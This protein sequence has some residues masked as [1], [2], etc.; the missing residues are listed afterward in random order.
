[1]NINSVS[2][3]TIHVI[4]DSHA[5]AFKHKSIALP[6][7]GMIFS[8]NVSYVRG[9]QPDTI[10]PNGKL[11]NGIAQFLINEGLISGDGKPA[12][13]TSEPA[14]LS[15]QYATGECFQTELVVFNVGEIYVRKYLGTLSTDDLSDDAKIEADFRSVIE[16]YVSNISGMRRAFR[17]RFC[18]HE[19]TPPTA[20]DKAFEAVNNLSFPRER[21]GAVYRLFNSLLGQY[22]SKAGLDFCQSSDYLAD[23]TGCLNADYEFD[24]VH[25]DPKYSL[26][27]MARVVR[28]W[29][30]SR[31]SDSTLRY[32]TWNALVNVSKVPPKISQIGVSEPVQAVDSAQIERLRKAVSDLDYFICTRPKHDWGH[33]PPD[34]DFPK[35]KDVIKYGSISLDGLK[36][37]HDVFVVGSIG[38]S[39]RSQIGSKFAIIN[40]RPVESTPHDGDGIGQQSF[41][42]DNCPPGIFRGLLYL[43]DVEADEGGFEY[44]PV[45]GSEEPVQVLGKAGS[46]ILFDANAVDHRA[47]PPRTKTR[48][49]LDFIILAIPDDAD[50]IVH[51]AERG[52]IWPVDPYMFSLTGLCYPPSSKGKWFFPSLISPK[53]E[54]Q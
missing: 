8:A 43:V 45:D 5:L 19:L 3:K 15:E 36:L 30:Y 29:L 44:K 39:M 23:E 47:S 11:N 37:L 20:D 2:P 27:S 28:T 42:R 54:A 31:T 26:I 38:D 32:S 33:A 18:I 51:C 50:E 24:G 21:R 34:K 14:I 40:V 10:L 52:I 22:T 35:F 49:A 41:H 1:M 12:A 25:A 17:L 7:L 13:L 16:T 9:L 4:G 53:K 46:W 6:E 48:L